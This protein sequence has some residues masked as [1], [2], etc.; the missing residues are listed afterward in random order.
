LLRKHS[1][2]P[3]T[4]RWRLVTRKMPRH[5]SGMSRRA[6][7]TEKKAIMLLISIA[8]NMHTMLMTLIQREMAPTQHTMLRGGAATPR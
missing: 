5:E 4:M 8:R 7:P 1:H 6:H 3:G 2:P